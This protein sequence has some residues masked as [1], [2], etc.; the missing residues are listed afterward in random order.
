LNEV[1]AQPLSDFNAAV[2]GLD[3]QPVS[4]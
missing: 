2:S 4:S 1:L 3:V